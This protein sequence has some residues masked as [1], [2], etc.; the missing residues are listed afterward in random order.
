MQDKLKLDNQLCFALYAASKEVVRLYKPILDKHGLTY[1]QYIVMMVLW[2]VKTTSVK[3]LGEKVRLD[4]G[5]LSPLL[6]KL[7]DMGHITKDRDINDFRVV[8]VKLTEQGKNLKEKMTSVPDEILCKIPV[9]LK[10][11]YSLKLSLDSLIKNIES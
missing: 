5:T 8:I 1:T 7:A 2:E 11:L 4:S 3:D 10:E 9:D 6:N